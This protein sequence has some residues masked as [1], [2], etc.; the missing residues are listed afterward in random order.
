M[1]YQV[2]VTSYPYNQ[3]AGSCQ[4]CQ[5]IW[6]GRY[7]SNPS[8]N[9]NYTFEKE[10]QANLVGTSKLNWTRVPRPPY[11]LHLWHWYFSPSLYLRLHK[12]SST[13]WG[14]NTSRS[15]SWRVG[16]ICLGQTKCGLLLLSN[17]MQSSPVRQWWGE[18]QSRALG[19]VPDPVV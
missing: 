19:S 16:L 10:G 12:N 1:K 8:Y 6:L 9:G 14:R 2:T 5:V 17:P 18:I 11:Y 3:P 7:N 4:I 15:G 13:I